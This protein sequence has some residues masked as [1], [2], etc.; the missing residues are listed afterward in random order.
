MKPFLSP[1]VLFFTRFRKGFIFFAFF[2]IAL[3][4][5]C[6]LKTTPKE[7]YEIICP[8]EWNTINLFGQDKQVSGFLS[9]LLRHIAQEEGID[10]QITYVAESDVSTLME[11]KEFDA[12]L[13]G[14]VP[15]FFS[16]K[17][18]YFS[19][20]LFASGH[21]LIVSKN[22]SYQQLS[23][24]I[25]MQ[26]GFVRASFHYVVSQLPATWRVYP[27]ETVYMALNDLLKKRI[28]GVILESLNMKGVLSEF[29]PLALKPIFPPLSVH[30]IRLLSLQSSKGKT[31]IH[32]IEN[33]LEVLQKKNA[34]QPLLHYWDLIS[35]TV[36]SQES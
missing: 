16:E 36:P 33:G 15:S 8:V 2:F 34:I 22:S 4:L 13:S 35:L 23:D 18:Y 1:F 17:T 19:P 10:I 5:A 32:H 26:V 31:L 9:D 14:L 11:R 3:I 6:S 28:N 30:E 29:Y 25:N 7:R 21:L 27:Y 20:P 24:C 12:F